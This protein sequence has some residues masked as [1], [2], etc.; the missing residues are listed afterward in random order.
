MV[1][2]KFAALLCVLQ[3]RQLHNL[4]QQ[5]TILL[6]VISSVLAAPCRLRQ[7]RDNRIVQL[8]IVTLINEI[9]FNN[10][11]LLLLR[12]RW[13]LLLALWV[14]C[15]SVQHRVAMLSAPA[16]IRRLLL[17]NILLLLLLMLVRNHGWL[18]Y[19]LRSL[20][21]VIS[22]LNLVNLLRFLLLIHAPGRELMFNIIS[23]D[24]YLFLLA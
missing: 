14:S 10:N 15:A 19:T 16:I 17:S 21:H 13:L 6:W 2:I 8:R 7:T 22:L 11:S 1:Q 5:T 23:F 4:F 24:F 9:I 18:C 20:I 3:L 12:W